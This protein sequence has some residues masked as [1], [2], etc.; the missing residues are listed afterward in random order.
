[1]VR[2]VERPLFP[3][4]GIAQQLL[5]TPHKKPS[6]KVFTTEKNQTNVIS[7]RG[8][9]G[10]ATITVDQKGETWYDFARTVQ[11]HPRSSSLFGPLS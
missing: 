3:D 4:P 1:M 5:G 10:L 11:Q 2:D 8:K 6:V 9:A 7:N